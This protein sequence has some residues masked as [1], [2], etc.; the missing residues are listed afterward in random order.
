[1]LY[2]MGVAV[3]GARRRRT[4]ENCAGERERLIAAALYHRRPVYMAFPTDYATAPVIGTGVPHA[5]PVS[6][7]G[8]LAAAVK[9]VLAVIES[10]RTAC[11]LPGMLL[12]PLRL[13]ADAT[14]SLPASH[15]PFANILAHPTLP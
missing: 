9:A 3:V 12:S 8:A 1:M 10:A 11:I 5:A 7:P 15:L 13:R 2:K 14:P 6:D 4:L